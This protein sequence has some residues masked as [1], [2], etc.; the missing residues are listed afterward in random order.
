MI[1]EYESKD[2]IKKVQLEK[3]I[4]HLSSAHK[5]TD[6][7]IFIKEC[8]SLANNGY[9]V[10]LI[11]VGPAY[12]YHAIK[13]IPFPELPRLKRLLFGPSIMLKVALLENADIYHLHDPELLTIALKLKRNGKKVIF[14]SHEHVSEQIR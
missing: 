3:K 11:A 13:V 9:E 10:S 1:V 6:A 4:C 8:T 7:R 14:D 5:S 12:D 2:E